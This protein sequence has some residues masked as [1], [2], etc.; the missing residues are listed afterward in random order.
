M[1][2][3]LPSFPATSMCWQRAALLKG[4][5]TKKNQGQ[6]SLSLPEKGSKIT[7]LGEGRLWDHLPWQA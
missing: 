7:Q 2:H 6:F 5:A 4:K 1:V 3:C